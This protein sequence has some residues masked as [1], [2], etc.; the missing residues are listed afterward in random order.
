M[1]VP[2]A[3]S[4]RI[5]G[6]PPS[7]GQAEEEG[8]AAAGVG[9]EEGGAARF[10]RG[11]QGARP[12]D[13]AEEHRDREPPAAPEGGP[14]R[15]QGGDER[16]Q[17]TCDQENAR[18]RDLERP[19]RNGGGGPGGEDHELREEGEE[20]VRRR[21]EPR[22]PHP[23]EGERG[24]QGRHEKCEGNGEGGGRDEEEVGDQPD[25]VGFVKVEGG[26]GDHRQENDP[27]Q[28]RELEEFV[29]PPR[30]RPKEGGIGRP[31]Q[32][33]QGEEDGGHGDEG[34]LEAGVP[35]KAGLD[36]EDD[37]GGEKNRVQ[38]AARALEDSREEV[39]HHHDR[40]PDGGDPRPGQEGEEHDQQ[41]R[42]EGGRLRRCPDERAQGEGP[43][44]EAADEGVEEEIEGK[45][46]EA[47][48]KAADGEEVGHPGA[49]E[50]IPDRAGEVLAD[51]EGHGFKEPGRIGRGGPLKMVPHPVP[52]G[53]QAAPPGGPLAG[54]EPLERPGGGVALG[55][56]APEAEKLPVVEPAGVEVA[57]GGKEADPP[58]KDPVA[59]LQFRQERARQGD[60]DRSLG[61]D[62]HPPDDEAL[63]CD[64]DS[65][66]S[67]REPF[68]GAGDVADEV[69]PLPG[70]GAEQVG[71]GKGPPVEGRDGERA[72][73]AEGHEPQ[74]AGGAPV[75]QPSRAAR[76]ARGRR[77]SKKERRRQ[78]GAPQRQ[79]GR[80]GVRQKARDISGRQKGE[81]AHVVS[82]Q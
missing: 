24:A 81:R 14:P 13:E 26:E 62:R 54:D 69:G 37:E 79:I 80:E 3:P 71:G 11:G 34:E 22:G 39:G 33:P 82:T 51:P 41:N 47:D 40:G 12:E 8:V 76:H 30:P 74:G 18:R 7:V 45:G 42:G 55:V 77:E 21:E 49:A 5:E 68:D 17:E 32:P 20:R 31:H 23:G 66:P 6:H 43:G 50:G 60:L 59:D 78:G 27:L 9:E 25:G 65:R 19:A 67:A 16:G 63:G 58:E 53:E 48:V 57:P 61:R 38:R 10:R 44:R 64:A 15:P 72:R 29:P 52:E 28:A 73:R 56:N 75:S 70:E 46:D 2:P 4:P 1:V 35:E 36:D